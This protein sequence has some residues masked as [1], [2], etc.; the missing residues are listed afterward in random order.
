MSDWPRAFPLTWWR[1]TPGSTTTYHATLV[2]HGP[3][4]AAVRLE[5]RSPTELLFIIELQ[6][7]LFWLDLARDA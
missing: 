6:L 4:H 2:Q 7:P 3:D 1:D 5:R